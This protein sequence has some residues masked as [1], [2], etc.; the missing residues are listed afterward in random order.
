MQRFIKS[1]ASPY[2]VDFVFVIVERSASLLPVKG[3]YNSFVVFYFVF[4]IK[5]LLVKVVPFF[6]PNVKTSLQNLQKFSLL[7]F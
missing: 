4:V 6:I 7:Q 5:E 1:N 2:R 3:Q